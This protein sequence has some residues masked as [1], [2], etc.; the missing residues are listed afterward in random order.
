MCRARFGV[1]NDMYLELIDEGINDVK[2]VGING[3]QYI[4]DSLDCMI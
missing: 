3:Y 1:L 4:D 2:F